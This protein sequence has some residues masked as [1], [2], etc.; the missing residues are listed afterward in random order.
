MYN[1]NNIWNIAMMTD[2]Y[3]ASHWKQYPKKTT[4][5]VS[6]LESRGSKLSDHTLFFG[7]QYYIKRYLSGNVIDKNGVDIAEKF[8]TEHLGPGVFDRTKWDYIVEKYNGMLPIKICAVREGNRVKNHNVLLTIE[9]TDPECFWLTNFLETLILKVWYSIS[10]ATNSN[11][12]RET[13]LKYLNETGSPELIDW[14][15][16]DF[17]FRG[18]SSE[19]SA[20]IGAMA[21]L[22][23]FNGTDTV[24]GIWYAREFYNTNA[25][26]A[27]S[28]PA[29]EHSTITSWLEKNEVDAFE[30]MLDS[31]PNGLVACVLDSFNFDKALD[32]WATLKEKILSRNGTLVIRPDSGDPTQTALY[33]IN[34]LG[35]LF[36]YTVNEKEYK[37]LDPHVRVIY[38][39][40]INH[41]SI[42]KILETL[43]KNSWS[44]DNITFG[45]GGKLLQAFDRDTFNFAIKCCVAEVDG[46]IR[47]VEKSPIEID[48]NGKFIMSFK[49]SKKGY[50]KLIKNSENEFETINYEDP[51]FENVVDELIPVFENGKI[52]REYTFEEIR[53]TARN[54]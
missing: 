13:I 48:E 37:V 19:E 39:D 43:K 15:L 51:R 11:N 33:V 28:I 2:S 41:E 32:K 27:G 17:G 10:V 22:A 50:L 31:Y 4:K 46:E 7:L 20:G 16:H 30:N 25:M 49:K 35:N 52:L 53:E 54:S 9:N 21:H 38:G 5:I 14:K 18:V 47:Y 40:G 24:A 29:S 6:Y 23:S 26:V 36:G 34:K 3:K 1:W 42:K 45:C 8:W 12:I 44:A